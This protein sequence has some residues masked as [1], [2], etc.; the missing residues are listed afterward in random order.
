MELQTMLLATTL[1]LCCG[2]LWAGFYSAQAEERNCWVTRDAYPQLYRDCW[3]MIQSSCTNLHSHKP[4]FIRYQ[5]SNTNACLFRCWLLLQNKLC[6]QARLRATSEIG[7]FKGWYSVPQWSEWFPFLCCCFISWS[8]C[9]ASVSQVSESLPPNPQLFTPYIHCKLRLHEN[10]RLLLMVK[11]VLPSS[12]CDL[13]SQ[14]W[15]PSLFHTP[16]VP[17]SWHPLSL[18]ILHC[19]ITEP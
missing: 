14:D 1:P 6:C 7:W 3:I 17:I 18:V 16:G 5:F 4:A 2:H 11:K 8:H 15:W 10:K 9:T 19:G 13:C 12:K